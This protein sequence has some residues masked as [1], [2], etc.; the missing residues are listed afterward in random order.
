MSNSVK[1]DKV[2]IFFL[3][4]FFDSDPQITVIKIVSVVT[5]DIWSLAI[6]A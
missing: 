1:W 5:H 3:C 6:S 4:Y 2:L